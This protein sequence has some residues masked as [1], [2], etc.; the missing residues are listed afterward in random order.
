MGT[1]ACRLSLG[2][3]VGPSEACSVGFK[4]GEGVG[5][6]VV[7]ALEGLFVGLVEGFC[8]ELSKELFDGLAEGLFDGLF[9]GLAEGLDDGL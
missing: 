8:E 6:L 7:W 9:E 2:D 4:E 1:V 5:R 3:E